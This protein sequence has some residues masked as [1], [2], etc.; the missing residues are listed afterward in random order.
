MICWTVG[1]IAITSMVARAPTRA[2][3][4]SRSPARTKGEPLPAGA[5]SVCSV[6]DGDGE[7]N[8]TRR[9]ASLKVIHT[10]EVGP[11]GL[12]PCPPD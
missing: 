7:M 9:W 2:S 5:C 10:H 4:N 8:G 12:E 3:A 6:P 11:Q 1:P